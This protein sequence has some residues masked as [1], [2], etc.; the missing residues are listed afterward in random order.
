MQ[1]FT[2]ASALTQAV[3]ELQAAASL[4]GVAVSNCT[5]RNRKKVSRIYTAFFA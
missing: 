3:C 1:L 2:A 5:M 4:T